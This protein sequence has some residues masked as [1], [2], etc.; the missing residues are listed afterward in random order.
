MS[1]SGARETIGWRVNLLA[2]LM[3]QALKARTADRGVLPG[4]Y[5]LLAALWEEDGLTQKQLVERVAIDQSTSAHTLKRMERDGLLVR[6]PCETDGRAVRHWLTPHGRAIR[7]EIAEAVAAV[8]A[9]TLAGLPPEEVAR[10][11]ETLDAMIANLDP[12]RAQAD[13]AGATAALAAPAED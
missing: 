9:D 2:R 8:N 3:A 6:S 5:P 4:Q 12:R 13:A 10:L 1:R 11:V 7:A